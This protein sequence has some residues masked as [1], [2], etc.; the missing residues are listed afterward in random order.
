MHF[1]Q[2]MLDYIGFEDNFDKVFTA[3]THISAF[4]KMLNHDETDFRSLMVATPSRTF[5]ARCT[6]HSR[7][8]M[9]GSASGYIQGVQLFKRYYV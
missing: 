1:I 5:L 6:L 9:A 7:G 4:H 2:S 3:D 8:T